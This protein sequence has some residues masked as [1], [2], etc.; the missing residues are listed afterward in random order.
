MSTYNHLTREERYH[1]QTLRKQNVSISQIAKGM[2]RNKGTVSRELKRNTGQRGYRY[3]QAD[4]MAKQRH[5]D[6]PKAVK[7]IGEL[8]TYVTECLREH[9]SPEQISGRLKLKGQPTASHETIYRFVSAD[10]EAGGDLYTL[11]RHPAKPYRKR[12]GKHDYR[13]RIPNRVDI[14]QRPT[15]VDEKSRLGDWEADTVIGKGHKGVFVTLTE[16]VS[17]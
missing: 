3:Q 7:I 1:I 17:L 15:V 2:G 6:K 10:R 5:A 14:D 11:L 9:W 12:Y 16:R 13:G 4:G 8:K